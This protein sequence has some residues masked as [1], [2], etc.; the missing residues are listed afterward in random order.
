MAE[1]TGSKSDLEKI[2]VDLLPPFSLLGIAR[3]FGFGARKYA[4]FNYRGGIEYLRLYGAALRHLFSWYMREDNDPETGESHLLHAMC[5]I[6]M[7]HEMTKIR[8][9][10]DDRPTT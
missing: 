6:I 10:L 1:A 9:D 8:P 4:R 3:V 7:L 5:S 2:A